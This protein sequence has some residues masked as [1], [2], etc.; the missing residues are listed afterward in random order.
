MNYCRVYWRMPTRSCPSD[1]TVEKILRKTIRY[2]FPPCPLFS[3]PFLSCSNLNFL[4]SSVNFGSKTIHFRH[5]TTFSYTPENL[6]PHS[7]D[8][9]LG[10]DWNRS[11]AHRHRLSC[12]LSLV[13]RCFSF[14]VVK[15]RFISWDNP[16]GV[17]EPIMAKKRSREEVA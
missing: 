9:R 3:L 1:R 6:S 13:F 12:L 8:R 4:L 5:S 17:A 2:W 11:S 15:V 10:A 14:D 7:H 16:K